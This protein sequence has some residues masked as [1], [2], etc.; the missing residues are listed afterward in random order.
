MSLYKRTDANE[1]VD[2]MYTKVEYGNTTYGDIV[3]VDST[4]ASLEVNRKR[5]LKTPGWNF[6][7]SY[8]DAQGNKRYK[9]EVLVA[10][11][12]TDSNANETQS[13][14][15]IAADVQSVITIT[16]HP[17]NTTIVDGNDTFME[18]AGTST[19]SGVVAYDWQYRETQSDTWKWIYNMEELGTNF[20]DFDT[21]TMTID[22]AV[23]AMTGWQF[24]CRLRNDLGAEPVFTNTATLTVTE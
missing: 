2:E 21:G 10:L 18:A 6:I 15:N 16:T 13:D 1:N 14:D 20:T 7:Q 24:R 4:E 17:S 3:F 12:Q 5:G 19:A 22:P 8:T 23:S 11:N 9:N